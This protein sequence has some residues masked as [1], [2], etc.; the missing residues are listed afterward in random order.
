MKHTIKKVAVLGSGIMGSR[1]ACHFANIGVNV[2][3]LDIV[4]KELTNE[5]KVKGLTLENKVIRNRIV[6]TAL[7]TALKSNPAPLYKKDFASRISTGNF[8]DDLPKIADADWIIEA[9]VE[10][11]NIKKQLFEKVEKFRKQNTIITSNT[12]GIPIEMLITGRTDNFQK[13]FCGTHFFNPPRYLKL[14]EII[15]S[16]K[17]DPQLTDFLMHYGDLYLGKTT[18]L[19]KDTPA[20]IGNRIGIYSIM[21]LFHLVDKMGLTVDEVDT[22]TG[23]LIGRPKSATFR[24]CDVVGTDTLV[25]VAQFIYDTCKNDH[26]RELFKLPAFVEKLAQNKWFGDKSKQ[27]FYKKIKGQN[28]QSEILSLDIKSFDYKAKQKVK[29]P[30][31]E[32]IRPLENLKERLVGLAKSQD[33]AGEFFRA[34]FYGL[35]E[36]ASHKIPEITDAL[37]KIDAAMKGGFGWE[38]GLF[39]IWDTLNPEKTVEMMEKSGFKAA[40]WVH[41]MLKNQ[42]KT[43]YIVK[44]G[45][46]NF[47]DVTSQS[48]KLVPGANEFIILDNM[49]TTNVVW[50]NSG[51]TL[52]DI[53][54]GVLNLEFHTKM[55][56]IGGEVVE[57]IIKAVESSEKDFRGLIIANDGENFSAGANLALLLMNAVEQEFE[58]IDFMVKTFQN[59]MMRVKYSCIPVIVAPHGLTLGGGCELSLHAAKIQ[60]AAETYIGLVE[61]GVGLIPS[62]GG[63]KE[64]VI[65]AS[66]SFT[67]GDLELPTLKEKFL[68]IGMAKVS[69]SAFEAFD[70]G[71]FKKG[72][73]EVTINRNRLIADAK[74]A[75]LELINAGYT[76]PIPRKNI[77]VVGR[78]GLGMFEAGIYNMLAGNFMSE[79]DKLISKKLANIMCGGDLTSS[80]FVSEQY[81]LDLEREAFLSLCGEKKTLE[82]I[83]SILNTG[84]VLRN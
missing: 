44:D 69:T 1:I 26:A 28:G 14:L 47:Y 39:E 45:I 12:S 40:S 34:S 59:M 72:H 70:L 37:H 9:V 23:P 22:L 27:G 18:V 43:F 6:N 13:N 5:E 20:F 57:G 75:V 35:F 31:L 80:T 84:K 82:R 2:L 48:Y 16:T 19:C 7:Q 68:T 67:E 53:G 58:E 76:P 10:D 42:N 24:T 4:P 52:L 29:I 61:F 62:G 71:I 15:P 8:E 63:T 11:L 36:Y 33:K 54:D 81:L 3:L 25:K 46:K 66:D 60:A 77:K 78:T 38:L 30:S 50:K 49:R 73:D 41:D 79:H 65:R 32:A 55:N 74:K 51:T 64:F 56:T 83:Q 21:S 17:T